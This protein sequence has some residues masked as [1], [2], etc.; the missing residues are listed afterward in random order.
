MDK[1]FKGKGNRLKKTM[2]AIG[3]VCVF[4]A[5]VMFLTKWVVLNLAPQFAD[6][7]EDRVN[8]ENIKEE[9]YKDTIEEALASQ[10]ALTPWQQVIE[11]EIF[12]IR[13]GERM[14]IIYRATSEKKDAFV[15]A[16]L[17][18]V[19]KN[20]REQYACP[21]VSLTTIDDE[22]KAYDEWIAKKNQDIVKMQIAGV[23]N[24]AYT[25]FI[26]SASGDEAENNRTTVY[27]VVSDAYLTEGQSIYH[28]RIDDKSPDEIVECESRGGKYYFWYYDELSNATSVTKEQITL[29]EQ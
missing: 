5:A 29:T 26:N 15:S 6:A 18:V 22:S 17:R 19:E 11:E 2:V 25:L 28:L 24:L 4:F 13:K 23:A 1:E 9:D 21:S 16:N 12:R 14:C 20:G 7:V 10:Q 8:G 3:L 27:G